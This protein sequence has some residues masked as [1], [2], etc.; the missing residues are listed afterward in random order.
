MNCIAL[1]LSFTVDM[2]FVVYHCH[3]S[4]WLLKRRQNVYEIKT[5]I[6]VKTSCYV[7]RIFYRIFGVMTCGAQAVWLF[8]YICNQY[9]IGS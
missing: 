5:D 7:V 6:T 2:G 1:Y 3:C 9:F 8:N 4:Q